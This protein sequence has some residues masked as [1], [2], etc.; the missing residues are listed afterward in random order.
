MPIMMGFVLAFKGGPKN[1]FAALLVITTAQTA[2]IWNVGIKTAAA[3]NM[4]A[5]GFIEN[6]WADHLG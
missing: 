4:V 1:R 3:Q 5:I 6:S 2:S